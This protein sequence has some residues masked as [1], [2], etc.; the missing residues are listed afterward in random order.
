MLNPTHAPKWL[1]LPMLVAGLTACNPVFAPPIRSVHMGSPRP[2]RPGAVEVSGAAGVPYGNG[3]ATVSLAVADAVW[4]DGSVD[5]RFVGDEK[6]TIGNA[7][8]R[9]MLFQEPGKETGFFM[10]IELG[11]GAGAGGVD[12]GRYD[13]EEKLANKPEENPDWNNRFAFGAFAG[14]GAAYQV[15]GWFS[16]FLRA[17][18]QVSKAEFVP[19]TLWVSSL[20]GPQFYVGPVSL[21][22]SCGVGYYHNAMDE[23]VGLLPE[24][25]LLLRL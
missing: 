15:T 19:T 1:A 24:A 3:A 4:L 22:L 21:Y 9:F 23:Q 17:R 13:T 2:T 7:G 8:V 18:V 12:Q 14:A 6:W 25:G 11:A 20:T 5:M 10:D 16:W